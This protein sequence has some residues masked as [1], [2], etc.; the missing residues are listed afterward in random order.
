MLGIIAAVIFGLQFD[1]TGI[2]FAT[3]LMVVAMGLIQKLYIEGVL[4]S[5]QATA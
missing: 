4:E 5:K 2:I 3:P 1:I